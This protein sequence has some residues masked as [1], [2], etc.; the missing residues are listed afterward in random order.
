MQTS[1]T[2]LGRVAVGWLPA[3]LTLLLVHAEERPE[4]RLGIRWPAGARHPWLSAEASEEAVTVIERSSEFRAWTEVLRGHG[5]VLAAPDLSADGASQ[6]FYRAVLHRR[7][8]LDD[9]KNVLR[10]PVD[11]FLSPEPPPADLESR[12]VKFTI[13]LDAPY[14][15]FF[16]DS[17]KYPFHYDFATAR[18]PE[19]KGLSRAQFDTLTLHTNRQRAVLGAVLFPPATNLLEAGIQL[20]GLDAYPR[21]AVAGWFETV[22]PMIGLTPSVQVFYLPTFEQREVALANSTWFA[23][24][25]IP[26]SSMSRWV[27]ADEIYAPGWALGRWVFVSAEDIGAAYRDGRLKPDDL[28][29]TDAVPAEVPPLA[30]I[31]TLSPATPNSHVALL[32][33]SFGIP[34]VHVAESNFVEQAMLWVGREVLLRAIEFAEERQVTVVPLASAL[35]PALRA[36]I[37]ALKVPPRLNLPAKTAAG[38]LSA[39]TETLA[40]SDIRVVGGKAANFGVLRRS[41]PQHSPAPA[42]ALTFDLWDAYLDQV[43]PGSETLRETVARRLGDFTWPPDMAALQ[44]ALAEV[45]DLFTDTADFSPAQRA[46]IL[47]VLQDAGFDANRN[48]RFRSSTNVEDSEQFSGAGLYDSYSGCLAD[49]LDDDSR[50]P[51]HCDPTE[52]RERGV[53][54]ALRRV[55]ASFYNDNAF[56]ERLRHGVDESQVGMAVLV[57]HSTPDALELANGVATLTVRQYASGS[58]QINGSLITQLGAVSVTNP[59]TAARPEEVRVVDFS[60]GSKPFLSVVTRSS[61]VPLGDT[62]L[63]WE[64]EYQELYGLLKAAAQQWQRELGTNEVITL[65]FEYKKEVPDRL[66]VKQIRL[67]PPPSPIARVTPFLIG[68]TNRYAVFQG[69][70]GDVVSNHRLKSM[71]G[72]TTR[73]LQMT[74]S[75]LASTLFTAA[76]AEWR[77]DTNPVHFSG[78]ITGLPEYRFTRTDSYTADQ[79]ALGSGADRREFELRT[80]DL[81]PT[82]Q[83]LGPLRRLEDHRIELTVTYATPQPGLTSEDFAVT[84]TVMDRVWIAPVTPVTLHSKLQHRLLTRGRIVISTEYYWPRDVRETGA[85]YTAPVIAWVGTT[86][87]GLASR[88]ITLEGEFSQTCRPG[89]HN[90]WEDFVFDPWLEP[91]IDPDLL[92]ELARANVRAV[93]VRRGQPATPLDPATKRNEPQ[94]LP[95]TTPDPGEEVTMLLWGLDGTFRPAACCGQ[96]VG[97]HLSRPD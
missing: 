3:V 21:E 73:H 81:D 1:T 18:L 9:W 64:R 20:V 4:G 24:R 92:A 10:G 23:E 80:Y 27:I 53:F 30:G 42:L 38:R 65:D 34:F 29:L 2:H 40:P 69:E 86:L 31:V 52:A 56:L 93:I 25:G 11:P 46:A 54:R 7:T 48:V 89:H 12:W 67:L 49:D 87:T 63:T 37:A 61:L 41:I 72:L 47:A 68:T 96:R 75:N 19:F 36:E 94:A 91:G 35:S 13:P 57:H 83:W 71:W 74:S 70:F 32:A 17:T 95:V 84:N 97:P 76:E 60:S 39:G 77:H 90:I 58:W 82:I 5:P 50:G 33:R 62:V 6:R 59:D 45:R 8:E 28:L 51:S 79:W 14:R 66:S 78:P 16:Q 22:R 85:G 88:P 15:V 55:F 43:L 26:V 44:T